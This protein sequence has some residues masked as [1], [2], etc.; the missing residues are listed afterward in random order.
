M[1]FA[2]WLKEAEISI[3]TKVKSGSIF[4]VKELFDGVKWNNLP[5]GD[6]ISFGRFFSN[7][8]DEGNITG[9][10]KLPRGKN[11]HTRYTKL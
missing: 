6:R 7:E 4:E 5:K 2:K 10:K 11:N 9:I 3:K 1:D 8:V